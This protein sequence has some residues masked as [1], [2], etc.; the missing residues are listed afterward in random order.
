MTPRLR[1]R[2]RARAE[3]L[4]ARDWYE[5]RSPGLGLEFARA[6]EAALSVVLRMPEAFAPLRPD[7][8]HAVLRR[9][10]YS[11]LYAYENGVVIVLTVH[12]HKKAPT[13]W[14]GPRDV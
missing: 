13:R 3:L 10:P 5:A 12:H 9:F 11:I 2:P 7:V 8:R 6:V 4:E 14:H 1:F